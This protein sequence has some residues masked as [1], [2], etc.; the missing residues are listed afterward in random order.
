M[1]ENLPAYI[2]ISFALTTLLSIFCFS[3]AARHH[4]L[5]LLIVI[6]WLVLQGIIGFSKFYPQTH[7]TPP[8]F[9]LL[10]MPPLLLVLLMFVTPA[11]KRFT[12]SLDP[13]WLTYLHTIRIPVEFVLL[14]LYLHAQVPRLMTFEGR[15]FDIIAGL[16]APFVAYYGYTKHLLGRTFLLLW[17]FICLALLLNIVISAVLSIPFAYQQF[18]F[19]QPNVAILYFPF[20][21]L[22]CVIVPIVFYA[23]LAVIRQLLYLKNRFAVIE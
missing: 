21:W 14:G 16:S 5:T 2:A 20:V 10:G 19:D 18:G 15:N 3:M 7:T 4:R 17:N 6:A 1:I 23:H 9:A 13:K 8:R 22:P 11:G 12:D